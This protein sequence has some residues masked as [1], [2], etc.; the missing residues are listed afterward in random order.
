MLPI[1][2]FKILVYHEMSWLQNSSVYHDFHLS[3]YDSDGQSLSIPQ[4]GAELSKTCHQYSD[5]HYLIRGFIAK[6]LIATVK[7]QQLCDSLLRS[8]SFHDGPRRDLLQV[9]RSACRKIDG[10]SH[11]TVTYY[12]ETHQLFLQVLGKHLKSRAGLVIVF[13]GN[14][15]Y[16][17]Q[18]VPSSS[19][20]VQNLTYDLSNEEVFHTVLLLDK[21]RHY[22]RTM[23]IKITLIE[24]SGYED[25]DCHYGGIAIFP[26]ESSKWEVSRALLKKRPVCGSVLKYLFGNDATP[27]PLARMT[28]IVLFTHYPYSSFQLLLQ[29]YNCR[30]C[31]L[32]LY[33]CMEMYAK[34]GKYREAFMWKYSRPKM[35]RTENI[36]TFPIQ[37]SDTECL[38]WPTYPGHSK[39]C[40]FRI[41]N[42]EKPVSA[43]FNITYYEPEIVRRSGC[44]PFLKY[45]LDNGNITKIAQHKR[46]I[47]LHGSSLLVNFS[48]GCRYFG[49]GFHISIQKSMEESILL[50]D[51]NRVVYLPMS[52]FKVHIPVTNGTYEI[53]RLLLENHAKGD[54]YN[55]KFNSTCDDRNISINLRIAE[56]HDLA[57]NVARVSERKLTSRKNNPHNVW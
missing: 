23:E 55:I 51:K 36:F 5:E 28:G 21:T 14:I 38:M 47:R 40:S 41:G 34:N 42:L 16:M 6:K 44:S 53:N 45:S 25:L 1:G 18:Y 35:S 43:T 32:F 22:E 30:T 7:Y 2:Q 8:F 49:A 26:V 19:N 11:S 13:E 46:H 54:H 24:W 10:K 37:S 17:I 56:R 39:Y 20:L 29:V 15:H 31:Q 4:P 57:S 3:K 12:G 50:S 33:P 27:F 9:N 52:H 48:Q